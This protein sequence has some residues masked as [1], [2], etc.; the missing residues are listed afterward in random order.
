MSKFVLIKPDIFLKDDIY[1]FRKEMLDSKSLMDGT[2]ALKSMNDIEEWLLFNH[3]CEKEETLPEHL[4][5][6]DQYM[7]VRESDNKIVGMIQFRHYFNEFLEKYGGN[8]GYS[9]RPSER[10]KGYAKRMLADCLNVCKSDGLDK[11]LI[12]C[13]KGNEGSKRTILA[14]GGVYENTIYC[15]PDDIYIERY[16]IHIGTRL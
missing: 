4:V 9:V 16:W 2:G 11:V 13:I 6:A 14:N 1:D 8:I 5:T 10:R 15:E 3:R 7:Y 12:T